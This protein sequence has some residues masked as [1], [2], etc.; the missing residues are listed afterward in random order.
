MLCSMLCENQKATDFH[1]SP[2]STPSYL[3][4]DLGQHFQRCYIGTE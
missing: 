1:L 2:P 3:F 4:W